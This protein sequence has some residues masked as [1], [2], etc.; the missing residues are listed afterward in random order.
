MTPIMPILV[1]NDRQVV[2]IDV[3]LGTSASAHR[4]R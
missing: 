3:E 1:A 4:P 2:V